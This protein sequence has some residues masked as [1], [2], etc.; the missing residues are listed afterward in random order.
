MSTTSPNPALER[1]LEQTRSR[2]NGHL[3]ELQQLSPGQLL[4]DA[5]RYF[6]G[7]EG[8]EFGRN[9]LQS[10][11]VNPL[12]AAVTG[13]GLT[14]LMA[15]HPRPSAPASAPRP[16][17]TSTFNVGGHAAMTAR[18][19]AAERGAVRRHDEPEQ[20]YIGRLDDARGRAL[21]LARHDEDTPESFSQRIAHALNSTQQA[22]VGHVHDLQGSAGAAAGSVGSFASSV[23]QGVT[24]AAQRAGSVMAHSGRATGE[25]G[26]SLIAALTESPVLLGALGLAAGALLGA[27]VPQSEREEA[28]LGELAGQARA[29]V[30]GLA[31]TAV[32]GGTHVAQAVLDK[33]RDSL[34][35]H[36]L[37]D[38][39]TPGRILDAALSGNLSGG[40][41]QV[42]EEV[43]E[44]G[45]VAIRK[46]IDTKTTDP[47][48]EEAPK[49]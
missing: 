44:A 24:D 33:G 26:G 37:A 25:A 19:Q 30:S 4:D 40:A 48:S 41:K 49:V 35:A 1:E 14:W 3:S 27:L 47:A 8:A 9:L 18:L 15:S 43:L 45:E 17:T 42:A 22:V 46:E 6:R 5:M 11:R 13:I 38:N 2:L 12:P 39:K 23:G 34:Q 29:S 32:D 20:A 16:T 10:V 36:E 31:Q 7:A 28:A 21:G